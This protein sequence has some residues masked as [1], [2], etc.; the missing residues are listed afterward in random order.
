MKNDNPQGKM[1]KAF[2]IIFFLVF[3]IALS[4]CDFQMKSAI[5]NYKGDGQ[6]K[7]LEAPG[8]LG[9]SGCSIKMPSFDLSK[10]F[11]KTY[12]LSGIPANKSYV[13]YLVVKDPAGIELIKQSHFC[14]QIKE[15]NKTIRNVSAS[16]K[17]FIASVSG[18]VTE[19]YYFKNRQPPETD[20]HV[21]MGYTELLTTILI[22]YQ[23]K[24][25]VNNQDGYLEIRFGGSK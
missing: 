20:V 15:D 24:A 3:L 8:I 4:G 14:F 21:P 7:Y 12:S 22:S 11:D 18:G 23:N 9:A 25:L 19:F 6:I 13:V 5:D 1:K 17:D 2:P 10:N 16:L